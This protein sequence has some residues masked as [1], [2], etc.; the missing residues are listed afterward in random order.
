MIHFGV[1][2]YEDIRSVFGGIDRRR[3]YE[4]CNRGTLRKLKNG[5]YAFNEFGKTEGFELL[6]SNKLCEPSYVSLEYVMSLEG[7]IP[8]AVFTI[9]AITT[10]KTTSYNTPLGTYDYRNIKKELFLGYE[11][12]PM[13]LSLT[14]TRVE[15]FVK[16]ATIEKAF[17]DFI[18]LKDKLLSKE[19]IKHYRFDR[20]GLK[21]MDKK[22]LSEYISIGKKKSSEINIANIISLYDING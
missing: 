6:I 22:K 3:I 5:Y 20:D 13:T 21:G 19:E 8:E 11:L 12:K 2:S 14:G 16:I 10:L 17:F 15:R 18:Y 4:W 7:L 1:F 9:T